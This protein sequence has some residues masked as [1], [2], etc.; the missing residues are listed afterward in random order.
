MSFGK[1]KKFKY[2][3]I[4]NIF[5]AMSPSKVRALPAFHALTGSDNTSFFSGTGKKSAYDKWCKQP[6]LTAAL[7]QLMDRPLTLS[8]E[9]ISV[10]ERFVVSL[11]STTCPLTKVDLAREQIFAQSSRTSEYL[12]PTKAALIE[13]IKRTTYQAGY[14]WGQSLIAKQVLKSKLLGLDFI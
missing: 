13:H 1:G 2:I 7:C 12:P 3:S 14:I 11:Y 8:D 4:H 5:D 9:V 6:D 10:I